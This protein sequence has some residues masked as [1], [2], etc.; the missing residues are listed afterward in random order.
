MW[1]ENRAGFS[2]LVQ[3]E[4]MEKVVVIYDSKYGSTERYARWIAEELSCP[5]KKRAE[6]GKDDLKNYDVIVYGGGLYAGGV[7]GIRLLTGSDKLLENKK[8]ILFT[9]GL[10]DPSDPEN[11][12]H[13]QESLGKVLTPDMMERFRIFHLRGGIDY[14]KLSLVHRSMMGMLVRMM[15]KKDPSELGEEDREILRTYGGTVDFV[16]LETARPVIECAR[17]AAV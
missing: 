3:E 7:S 2:V 5:L 8:V 6:A 13:I 14:G 1:R 11:V 12:K 4:I 16:N 17:E 15:K 10:A 9:C